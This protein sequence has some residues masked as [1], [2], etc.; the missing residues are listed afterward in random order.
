MRIF[1]FYKKN[2]IDIALLL[3]I[4]NAI[5][6]SEKGSFLISI[7]LKPSEILFLSDVTIKLL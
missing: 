4:S 3:N 6:I 7:S 5:L 2:K 1:N